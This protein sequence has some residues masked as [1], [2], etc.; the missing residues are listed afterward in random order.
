MG[1]SLLDLKCVPCQV[2]EPPLTKEEIENNLRSL[3]G[4]WQY[5]EGP[6]QIVREYTFSDFSKAVGF[7][8]QVA[9]LAE[10][11]GHHPNLYLY[12]YKKLRIELWTH[13][14]NGLHKNDFILAS[15]IE[16]LPRL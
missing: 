7:V 14:I 1:N 4:D 12:D 10:Q 15:K 11:E 6:D 5:Q 2:G 16:N 3:A 8:N 13:K 9:M